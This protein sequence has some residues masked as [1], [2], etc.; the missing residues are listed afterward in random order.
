M[1]P[2]LA[3]VGRPNTGKSTL[4]NRL[5][6]SR[7]ALVAELPGLTRDRH[8]GYATIAD[9]RVMIVDTGGLAGEDELAVAAEAQTWQAVAEAHCILFLVD[10]RSG[11]VPADETLAQRLRERGKPLLLV[12]NKCEG[13]PPGA[14]AEF[15][16]LG[17]SEVIPLS[18]KRGSGL[19]RLTAALAANLPDLPE[20][21]ADDP[22]GLPVAVIGRPNVGKSTLLNRLIG[23]EGLLATDIPGTTRDAIRIPVERDGK[24][25]LFIDTAG[26]RRRSQVKEG[27]ER[28]GVLAAVRALEAARVAVIMT[29]AR[30][31]ITGQDQRLA[32]L[33]LERGRAVV[34]ALNKWDGIEPDARH[35]AQVSSERRFAFVPFARQLQISALHGSGLE[36]LMKA[37]DEAGRADAADLPTPDLNR[38]LQQLVAH[39]PPPLVHGRRIKLRYAHQAGRSPPRIR[40]HGTQAEKLPAAYRRYLAAGFRDAFELEGVPLTLDFKSAPNPYSSPGSRRKTS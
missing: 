15:H 14:L 18:A 34:I 7:N 26:F 11:L 33:A 24:H 9:R 22:P 39:T 6:N 27:A 4:F 8:Y 12:A 23:E 5:T 21:E 36:K 3:L 2:V 19:S 10:A 40:I 20:V 30:E 28:L 16:A 32:R 31:G 13:L 17:F 37:V 25:Y 38:V 35:H 1:V 29:D